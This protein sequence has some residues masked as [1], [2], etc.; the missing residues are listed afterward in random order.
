MSFDKKIVCFDLRNINIKNLQN[1]FLENDF[2]DESI[3]EKLFEIVKNNLNEENKVDLVYIIN[4]VVFATSESDYN[5]ELQFREALVSDLLKLEPI[6]VSEIKPYVH[7]L[8]ELFSNSA[9]KNE[10]VSLVLNSLQVYGRDTDYLYPNFAKCVSVI[11]IESLEFKF[12][13]LFSP[14][15]KKF[16]NIHSYFK[17]KHPEANIFQDLKVAKI[18]FLS[19]YVLGYTFVIKNSKE[20]K[21]FWSIH[22]EEHLLALEKLKF[23]HMSVLDLNSILDKISQ[24]GIEK[25]SK[26][27]LD[28]LNSLEGNHFKNEKP[29]I[30]VGDLITNYNG[31]NKRIQKSEQKQTFQKVNLLESLELNGGEIVHYCFQFELLNRKFLMVLDKEKLYEILQDGDDILYVELTESWFY[32]LNSFEENHKIVFQISLNLNYVFSHQ[33]EYIESFELQLNMEKENNILDWV[34]QIRNRED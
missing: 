15:D 13:E 20:E 2:F 24:V 8:I 7:S 32:I 22:L 21:F 23:D 14:F 25:L 3:K 4:S 29:N 26:E 34:S 10:N 18:Y 12:S 17:E 28:F 9:N 5:P 11:D 6:T 31:M 1:W 33:A 16:K 27:E 19:N 30:I